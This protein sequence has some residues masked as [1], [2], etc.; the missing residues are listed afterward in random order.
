ML[1]NLRRRKDVL[2]L[3]TILVIISLPALVSY[4]TISQLEVIQA[5]GSIRV[6]TRNTPSAYYID[7]SGPAGFEYELAK[8]FADDLGVEIDLI[9]PDTINGLFQTIEK[10]DAH[11]VAAGINISSARQTSFEF[12]TPYAESISTVIYRLKQGIPAPKSVDDLIDKKTLVLAN[13]IQEEQLENIKSAHPN[14]AWQATSELTNTDILDKVFSQEVDYAIV[15]SSVYESQSS[16]YPGLNSAFTIGKSQPIAWVL[17]PNQDG[18]LKRAVNKFLEKPK[19]KTLIKSLKEKYFEK[20][21]P[22]NYFD[23]VTFKQDME[24][25][26]S[27]LEQYFYMAEQETDFDWMLLASIA[28]QESH[29]KADAVSPTG[30]RGIMMLTNAAAKEVGVADRTDPIQSIRGGAEYL[31][32]VKRKIPE[33]IKEPDHTWFALAG[34]NVGFGHLEDA[35]VL[36]QRANKDPD[37]WDDVK[38]FL[39]LLSKKKY[40]S[41]VKYGYARGQEPVQ[42]VANIKKYIELLEWEKQIQQ[43]RKARDA[44]L[45]AE[46]KAKTEPA[47]LIELQSIPATL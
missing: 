28:Y 39:P 9:I 38:E 12:S 32:N 35:R 6:A 30:V 17:T 47:A 19:T 1:F 2:H 33:R 26:L 29:W 27:C 44:S 36:T 20:R 40:F 31:L 42:Y 11:I 14:L 23:T 45:R 41:T 3:L 24:T 21:N 16:F 34:Y 46:Q 4:N 37:K 7:K 5:N 13:S 18:S 25:R 8:A 10:R 22:L 43:I 15:D